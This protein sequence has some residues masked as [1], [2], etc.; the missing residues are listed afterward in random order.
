MSEVLRVEH[1]AQRVVAYG[2]PVNPLKP[3][4]VRMCDRHGEYLHP[5]GARDPGCST[6]R[7]ERQQ[8][9]VAVRRPPRPPHEKGRGCSMCGLY[10]LPGRRRSWCSD[11]CVRIWWYATDGPLVLRE[12]TDLHGAICWACGAPSERLDVDHR[13]PLWSL[14]LDQRTELRWW[15]P[16]NLQLLCPTCH[17]DKTRYEAGLRAR[18]RRAAA[19]WA[20]WPGVG[21]WGPVVDESA[22]L[23]LEV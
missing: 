16:F 20:P 10:P 6:C 2:W 4:S 19:T 7:H 14:T 1:P 9:R 8:A 3:W 22:Q 13:R 21:L 15:L 18:V 5:L 12:L 17:K 11:E 23:S